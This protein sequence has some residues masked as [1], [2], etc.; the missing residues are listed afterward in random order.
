MILIGHI[1]LKLLKW[2]FNDI[3][4]NSMCDTCEID[5]ANIRDTHCPCAA[6]FIYKQARKVWGLEDVHRDP[7]VGF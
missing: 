4:F 1:K 3:C 6:G 7:T 5:K 2:L